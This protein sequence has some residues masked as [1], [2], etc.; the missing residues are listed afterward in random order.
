MLAVET[1]SSE[2][3]CGE[4]ANGTIP[5]CWSSRSPQ[6]FELFHLG[7]CHEDSEGR[8]EAMSILFKV[9]SQC[10]FGCWVAVSEKL[11]GTGFAEVPNDFAD[12]AGP[13]RDHEWMHAILGGN[14]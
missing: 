11:L 6:Y 2:L 13:A 10:G 3:A 5:S 4:P 12:S 8:R 14:G 7:I 1:A 9:A